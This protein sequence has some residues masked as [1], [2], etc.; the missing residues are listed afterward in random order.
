MD[1]QY[2][3]MNLFLP[4]LSSA[5][6]GFT[7]YYS[8][9]R[10]QPSLR[11]PFVLLLSYRLLFFMLQSLLFY[12]IYK[13]QTD[14]HYYYEALLELYA[15]F[16][17]YP[18]DIHRFFTGNYAQMHVST[19]LHF[20]LDTEVRLTFFLKILSPVFL[21]SA[22]N[23]Y[24]LGAWLTFLGSLCIMPFIS[25]FKNKPSLF[26]WLAVLC[27]PS[28]TIWTVGILKEA[29][30]LPVLFLLYYLVHKIITSKGKNI[31]AAGLFLFLL[32]L[33]WNVKYYVAAAFLLMCVIY[34]THT[35]V[36]ATKKNSVISICALFLLVTALGYL[37]PALKWNVLPE[38]VY[39]SNTLTCTRFADAY[40]CIPFDLDMTWTS[41]FLNYP[42]AMLYAFFS[43]FPWQIH[44]ITS[45]LAAM[46]N[47]MFVVLCV[48]MLYRWG[49]RKTKLSRLE[50]V[51]LV[52]II[53]I[54]ALL[55]LSSPN[56]GSFSR[57]R[58]F[59]LPV[60]AYILFKHSGIVYTSLF[61][62][63]KNRLAK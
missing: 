18:E 30:V 33:A 40:T 3:V 24:L 43:P 31:G 26:I 15:D 32:V 52:L 59:Y 62:R 58:I 44:N 7:C 22:N 2:Y 35:C 23:Y 57:Y 14:P 11:K 51:S 4:L 48:C 6:L 60:Y 17:Q 10:I 8:F 53:V 61:L 54:G 5:L 36:A 12:F 25:L 45:L 16:H 37:H 9:N 29:F 50:L 27:I 42:K 1:F 55:I 41:I 19:R 28:F 49:T 21:I 13:N 46:E 63:F 34:Y 20:Y 47:Y 39:I 38:V 56:I